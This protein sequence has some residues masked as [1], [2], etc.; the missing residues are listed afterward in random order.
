MI[1]VLVVSGCS[2][3]ITGT[4]VDVDTKQ[5]IEGAVVLVEWTKT[6]GKWIGLRATKLY[7]AIE[8]VT[9]KNGKF[10]ISGANSLF[11]NPPKIIVCKTNYIAWRNDYIFPEWK[12]KSEDG[13]QLQKV[14]Q[15]IKFEKKYSHKEH[16]DFIEYGF[17]SLYD[18]SVLKLPNFRKVIE[19]EKALA[20]KHD[21]Q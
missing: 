17:M 2:G 16:L 19:Q 8:T 3:S 5:P 1:M 7:E 15:I 20:E 9:D 18:L 10:S 13:N 12:K 11:V 4:V 14:I 21:S 6:S